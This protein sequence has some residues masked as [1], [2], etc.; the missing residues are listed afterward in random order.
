[1]YV[2]LSHWPFQIIGCISSWRVENE[3][4]GPRTSYY[5]YILHGRSHNLRYSHR[6]PRAAWWLIDVVLEQRAERRL[7][8][9]YR[10]ALKKLPLTVVARKRTVRR[11]WQRQKQAV[12][13]R[14]WQSPPGE[15]VV[16]R[17][18]CG[19]IVVLMVGYLKFLVLSLS[20]SPLVEFFPHRTRLVDS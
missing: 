18:G 16:A 20:L 6:T 7:D 11:Q 2:T 5:I 17:S 3:V 4:P 9:W 8:L 13:Q 15:L 14:Q 19:R 10:G 12:S 1:M